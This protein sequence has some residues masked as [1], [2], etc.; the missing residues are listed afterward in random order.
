MAKRIGVCILYNTNTF[1]KLSKEKGQIACEL[2]S[3]QL[4][5]PLCKQDKVQ[6]LLNIIFKFNEFHTWI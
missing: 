4:N 5:K 1:Q 3:P 2:Q 6:A